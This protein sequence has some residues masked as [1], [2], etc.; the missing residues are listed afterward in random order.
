M[1]KCKCEMHA[2][3]ACLSQV[4]ENFFTRESLLFAVSFMLLEIFSET[5]I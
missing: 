4:C 1:C 5:L 2:F 3:F